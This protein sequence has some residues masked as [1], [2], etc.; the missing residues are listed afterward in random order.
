MKGTRAYGFNCMYRVVRVNTIGAMGLNQILSVKPLCQSLNGDLF[1]DFLKN[2]LIPKL[3]V[4]IRF[5][6]GQP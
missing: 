3:L 4:W 2:E 6:H 1:K 5:G